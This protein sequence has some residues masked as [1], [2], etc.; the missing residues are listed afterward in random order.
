MDKFLKQICLANDIDPEKDGAEK[1][2][3]D[4]FTGNNAEPDHIEEEITYLCGSCGKAIDTSTRSLKLPIVRCPSC[5]T[6]NT[7]I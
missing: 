7:L 5:G 1:L 4:I 2:A 3:M 6:I